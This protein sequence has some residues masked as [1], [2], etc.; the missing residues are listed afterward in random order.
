MREFQRSRRIAV[1]G[2]AGAMTLI[3]VNDA[4]DLAGR[5]RLRQDD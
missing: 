1:D 2:I 3:T 5:P 4:L